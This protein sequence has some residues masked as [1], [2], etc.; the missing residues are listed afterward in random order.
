MDR[1]VTPEQIERGSAALAPFVQAWGLPL[2]PEN[3]DEMA[4]A[5]LVHG[6]KKGPIDPSEW[7]EI[8]RAVRAQ[9]EE[10]R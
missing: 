5:V 9:L 3:L 2:N 1:A 7:D 4:Y 10:I 8:E 6:S